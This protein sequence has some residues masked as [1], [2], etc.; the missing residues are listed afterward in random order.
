LSNES[1]SN[2][3]LHNDTAETSGVEPDGTVLTAETEEEI[4]SKKK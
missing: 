1:L 3:T 4:L 2:Q